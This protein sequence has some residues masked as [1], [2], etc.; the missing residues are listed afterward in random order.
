M[1]FFSFQTA[2]TGE[3][4]PN[5]YSGKPMLHV[6]MICP[7]GDEFNEDGYDGYGRFGGKDYYAAIAEANG[8]AVGEDEESQRLAAIGAVF[9]DNPSGKTDKFITPRIVMADFKGGWEAAKL[10][11]QNPDCEYQGFFYPD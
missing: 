8:L 2:D 9:K 10:L 11:P 3:S 5:V 1:G 4:I 6:K 7:N